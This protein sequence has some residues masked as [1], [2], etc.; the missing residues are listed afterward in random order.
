M[1]SVMS[2]K[3][4]KFQGEQL[5]TGAI[6]TQV[7]HSQIVW[8]VPVPGQ[9]LGRVPPQMQH[10]ATVEIVGGG[11]LRLVQEQNQDRTAWKV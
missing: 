9:S 1:Y 10:S 6:E 2:C 8:S 5:Y 7:R 4:P 11:G 3:I